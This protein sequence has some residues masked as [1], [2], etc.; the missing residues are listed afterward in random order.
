MQKIYR[1]IS[2]YV[3]SLNLKGVHKL[4]MEKTVFF[5]PPKQFCKLTP[6]HRSTNH[7][8][9]VSVHPREMCGTYFQKKYNFRTP[10]SMRKSKQTST[11]VKTF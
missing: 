10:K 3:Q 7:T 5:L 1:A 8:V 11:C 2:T 6:P 9:Q 4:E